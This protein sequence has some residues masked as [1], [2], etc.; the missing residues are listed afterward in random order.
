MRKKGKQMLASILLM[1]MLIGCQNSKPKEQDLIRINST[2]GEN[3][4]KVIFLMVDSL[5]Y[6]AIDQG[7]SKQELPA[8]KFLIE[9]GQYYKNLVSSFPTMSV[10]IDSSLLTGAYSDIHR[11]PGLA[12]YSTDNKKM[13]N[14]GT[15]PM[16]VLK[17][18]VNPVLADALIHLNGSHLNRDLPTIYEDLARHGLKSGSING[19]IYRGASAHK[20]SIPDWIQGPSS[21]PKEIDVKGP[22]LLSLGALSNPFQ[23]IKNLPDGLTNRMGLHNDFAI[24]A[25]KYLVQSNKLPDF[26]FVYLPDLDRE[27]HKKGPTGLRK[28]KELDQQLQSVLQTF[29]SP[30]KA[31]HDAIFIIASDSGMTR[32][33]PAEQNP[34]IDL[35]SLLGDAK[36]LRPGEAVSKETEIILAVNETM[37]YVYSLKVDRSLRDTANLLMND[38]GID[39]ISWKEKEWNYAIQGSTA[40]QIKFKAG[41]NLTDPYNQSWTVEQ[42]EEV[43]DLSLNMATHSLSY[44]QYPDVLKRLSSALRSHQGEFL[45]VTAKPGYEFT[46]GSSPTHKGGGGH[47]SIRKM[48]SLVP[49]IISGTDQKPE[50]L[51]MV[52]LKAYLLNLLTKKNQR[53]Q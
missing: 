38:P 20:L 11:I 49:L 30:E 34:V 42:D 19:L 23:G 3:A 37:A 21:L 46:G 29:G 13:I 7:I 50:Y 26:L 35:S 2:N 27:L 4:K 6:Q 16:E 22:D 52:D 17:H 15:G 45:V 39:F 1:S 9:H 36:I 43:L 53:I 32:I 48:E 47:G 33:L 18:G 31:L 24:E 8:L 44:D 51:R 28:V 5:M 41:G 40:K 14:Y 10:T 12:W 25:V